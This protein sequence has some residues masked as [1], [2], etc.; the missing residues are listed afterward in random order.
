MR[1]LL[2]FLVGCFFLAILLSFAGYIF[3]KRLPSLASKRMESALQVPVTIADMRLTLHS[4]DIDQCTISNLPHKTLTKAFSAEIISIQAPLT[5]YRKSHVTIDQI[6]IDQV[7]LG[8]EFDSPKG[9][10]GN[11][12][13]LMKN[14]EASTSSSQEDTTVL[15]RE[16]ILT[17]IQVDV[18][19]DTKGGSIKKLPPIDRLVFTNINTSEGLPMEQLLKSV[20]GQM[21]QSVFMKENIKNMLKETLELP[22]TPLQELIAPFKGLF[23]S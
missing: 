22:E 20:L 8:L 2:R 7:Y 17:N 14:L 19:Y 4:I 21:L 6:V 9:T 13:T 15:I 5:E 3:Y 12:S 18:V 23:G 1:L 11:W 10:Q 16:L